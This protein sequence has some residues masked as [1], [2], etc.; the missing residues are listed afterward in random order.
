MF[1][2]WRKLEYSQ[3]TTDLPQVTDKLYHIMLY[4][5]DI[6]VSRIRT[7]NLSGEMHSIAQH[8]NDTPQVNNVTDATLFNRPFSNFQ[9]DSKINRFSQIFQELFPF[10]LDKCVH[11]MQIS[12]KIILCIKFNVVTT[13]DFIKISSKINLFY[14]VEIAIQIFK[15]Y[16]QILCP[17]RCSSILFSK[18][19]IT[20]MKNLSK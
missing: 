19:E 6:F 14:K 9:P 10:N 15:T 11:F 8:C 3:K 13:C 5:V 20:H 7:H 4:R 16:P 1:Y 18:R 17:F 12:M 2:W